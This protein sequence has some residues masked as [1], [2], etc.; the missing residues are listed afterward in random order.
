MHEAFSDSLTHIVHVHTSC[1]DVCQIPEGCFSPWYFPDPFKTP[2]LR[3]VFLPKIRFHLL[4]NS[5]S[6]GSGDFAISM[7]PAGTLNAPVGSTLKMLKKIFSRLLFSRGTGCLFRII[8][9]E[10]E[11]GV[12]GSSQKAGRADQVVRTPT[13]HH[14][15]KLQQVQCITHPGAYAGF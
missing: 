9:C 1:G 5:Y 3:P 13:R 11:I 2:R 12:A 8:Y 7:R 6:L 4:T 15:E 10:G 14:V